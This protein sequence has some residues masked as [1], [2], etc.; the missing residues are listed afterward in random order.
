MDILIIVLEVIGG[1]LLVLFI[2]AAFTSDDYQVES[3]IA[4]NRTVPEVFDYIRL[5]KNQ[6]HYNKWVMADPNVRREFKG[7]DGTVGFFYAWDSDVKNVGKGE[8]TIKAII[9]N[10]I[11]DYDL[12]F[13][14][15]FEGKAGSYIET[16]AMPGGHTKVTWVF[17]GKRTYMMK[18]MHIALQLPKML[19]KDLATSLAHLKN[20]LEK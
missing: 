17:K 1:L 16:E 8:Q 20:V 3:D 6:I 9:E 4:I 11:I 7:T 10:K 19:T 14:K 13:I 18:V 15:P 2:A 5:L 12:R